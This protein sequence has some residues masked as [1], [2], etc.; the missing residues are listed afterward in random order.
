MSQA[1]ANG[2]AAGSSFALVAIGFALIYWAAG[3]FHFAH[4][5][6]ITVGAYA[7]YTFVTLLG[8]SPILGVPL[9]ISVAMLVGAGI[10]ICA[11]RPL[12]RSGASSSILLLASLGLFVAV[13]NVLSV[14]FGDVT[15]TLRAGPAGE[16][17]QI[18]GARVTWVQLD[19]AVIATALAL[20]VWVGVRFTR[21]GCMIRAVATD[22]DLAR[23]VGIPTDLTFVAVLAVGSMLAGAAGILIAYD[24]GLTPMMG[25]NALLM[26]FVAAIVGGVQSI[27]GVF[28]AGLLVGGLRHLGVWKLPT[29]WQDAIVFAVLILFLL[30]R[31]QGIFGRSL[32]RRPLS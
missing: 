32:S 2:F 8:W 11:Y 4:G 30:L 20:L 14:L 23:A 7:A 12:R 15:L 6:I 24:T 13:Q 1:L 5:A 27:I 31:P 19:T 10:E 9:A 26:G 3:F 18:L 17:F 16:A 28:L 21:A 25:F 29:Q 22:S